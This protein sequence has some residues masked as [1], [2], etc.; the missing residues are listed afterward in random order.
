MGC[1]PAF[2][3]N[4]STA[5]TALGM[6]TELTV[7]G[8]LNV[9]IGD[10]IDFKRFTAA[11]DGS[12][13]LEVRIGDPFV[14]EHSVVGSI[15][16]FDRD[17]KQL[18]TEPLSKNVLK[19]VLTWDVE[20]EVQYL[21]RIQASE[22]SSTYEIDLRLDLMSSDPCDGV[23]CE[24]GDICEDGECVALDD[25]DPPCS[26]NRTCSDGECVRKQ[27]SKKSACGG[28]KCGRGEYCSKSKNR[29]VK[30]PCHGKRCGAGKVCRSGV[31]KAKSKP[32]AKPSG[33]VAPRAS[34]D[35]DPACS[36]GATC[37]KGKCRYPPL[38]AKIVQSVPRG[39]TT[40]ITLNKGTT[41]KIK[42]GQSG[43]VS[44]VG[45]FKIIEAWEYRCKAI[46]S[47]PATKLAAKKSATIYR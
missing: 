20:K 12:A 35:C 11:N 41:H 37:K 33:T 7:D 2:V 10:A 31:C 43:K 16:V 42:V 40:I 30:D 24:D 29:C 22:G 14:G 21:I 32:K 23:L 25:C 44:G 3:D 45:S 26:S 28:Q 17:A 4:D 38:A 8:E 15:V 36:D 9:D 46:L 19:Y 13:T 34:G 39:Q 27:G 1:G 18:A 6:P 47:A 5:A